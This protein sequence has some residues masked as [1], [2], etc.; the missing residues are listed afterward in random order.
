MTIKEAEWSTRN[1]E[2]WYVLSSL[3]KCWHVPATIFSLISSLC[4]Y[5]FR[6]GLNT[7]SLDMATTIKASEITDFWQG[8]IWT[9]PD[10]D[11]K[12]LCRF[13][14]PKKNSENEIPF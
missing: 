5:S 6:R 11:T 4:I 7:C 9:L 13:R 8:M 14:E 10:R 12:W 2:I 1:L 3:N